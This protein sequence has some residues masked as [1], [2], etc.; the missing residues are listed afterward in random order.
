MVLRV[1]NGDVWLWCSVRIWLR[2]S[3]R[4]WGCRRCGEVREEARGCGVWLG[5]WGCGLV[6]RD[7]GGDGWLW[8]HGWVMRGVDDVGLWG[9]CGGV[10]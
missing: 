2:D 1:R 8:G 6:L 7:M 10:G 9:S 3:V 4:T 5:M